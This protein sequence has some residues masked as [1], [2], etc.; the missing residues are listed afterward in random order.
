[1]QPRRWAREKPMSLARTSKAPFV[2][3]YARVPTRPKPRAG[4]FAAQ[5]YKKQSDGVSSFVPFGSPFASKQ[6]FP[7]V[8]PFVFPFGCLLSD[9]S[10]RRGP[11]RAEKRDEGDRRRDSPSTTF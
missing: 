8:F 10:C 2:F 1:M 3:G 7:F 9:A 6:C 11:K 4:K 5:T